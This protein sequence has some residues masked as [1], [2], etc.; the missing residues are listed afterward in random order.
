MNSIKSDCES[1]NNRIL[2]IDDNPA[3]HDDFRRVLGGPHHDRL[4]AIQADEA[5]LFGLESTPVRQLVFEIDSAFQGTEGLEKVRTAAA[6]GQPYAMAFVDVRMPPGWDGIETILRI[7]KEFPEVQMVICTAYSDYSWDQ[8]AEAVGSSDSILI[9]KKPFDSVEVLQIAHALTR[10]WQ[11]SQAARRH[12]KELDELVSQRTAELRDA[13]ERLKR[14]IGERAAVEEALRRSE[15]R[16]S[17]AFQASPLPMCIQNSETGAFVD[18]NTSYETL[19]GY[20]RTELLASEFGQTTLWVDPETP[21]QIR[22]GFA[23]DHTVRGLVANLRTRRG[24]TRE[25]LI[26]AEQFALGGEQ[27]ILLILQDTTEK[28]QLENRLRHAQKMEAVG[29]LA[30]GIAHDFN[31]LLTV[32]LGN[33]SEQLHNSQ[34]EDGMKRALQQ[35]VLASE[36]ATILTRQLLAYSR[37]QIIQRRALDL[38]EAVEN[39]V[40]ML[41]RIIGEDIAIETTLGAQLPAAHA[42]P[43]SVDQVVMNL[44]LN[45]RDAMPDGGKLTLRTELCTIGKEHLGAQS[46]ARAGTFLCLTVKDT[47]CGMDANTLARIFEP[48]YTTKEQG[49]G[50]GMGLATVSGIVQQHDGWVEVQSELHR[51][52]TFCIYLPTNHSRITPRAVPT[53]VPVIEGSAE[54]A[55]TIL[56]VED[57]EMLREFVKSVLETVGYTVLVAANGAE[58]L[59]VWEREE[60]RVHLL[61]TDVVMP[62]N[63]SGWQ[64]ARRLI[65][66]KP[67]LKVIFM[68][69]YSAELISPEFEQGG[70][71]YF[72]PKPF[73]TEKLTNTVATCLRN[74]SAPATPGSIADYATSRACA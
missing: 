42:D 2:V 17:K 51:G 68:S 71:H 59:D 9:L 69:G 6:G 18:V 74:C 66:K 21:N 40:A 20:T 56:V 47:G 36:R 10:K 25:T 46:E 45:A 72:L 29:Q 41:R 28:S 19:V 33:S 49:K 73:L 64:L 70:S 48:F 39:N 16:F 12:V 22:A 61:F 34:L 43:T 53:A 4:E 62:E 57:E 63:I 38:N 15:E 55:A 14:E 27:H 11:L 67:D 31:N 8:I 7:W 44:I 65:M 37:K 30:A 50:T 54:R 13:N 26:S 35:V 52:A 60:G 1:T 32:I 5:V 58:A 24:E 23:H 3:I